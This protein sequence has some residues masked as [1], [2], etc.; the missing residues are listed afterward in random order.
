[1]LDHI[2]PSVSCDPLISP[3]VKTFKGII[4]NYVFKIFPNLRKTICKGKLW[5]TSY[6]VVTFDCVSA[7]TNEMYI[8]KQGK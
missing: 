3:I 1:M 4:T 8:R 6:Y 5:S 7:Q 2:H